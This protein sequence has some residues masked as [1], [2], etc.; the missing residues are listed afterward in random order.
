M[1]ESNNVQN[2]IA[3]ILCLCRNEG[4]YSSVLPVL[5]PNDVCFSLPVP[6]ERVEQADLSFETLLYDLAA[7][8]ISGRSQHAPMKLCSRFGP[9]FRFAPE[10]VQQLKRFHHART[11][12]VQFGCGYTSNGSRFATKTIL[13]R[14]GFQWTIGVLDSAARFSSFFISHINTASVITASCGPELQYQKTFCLFV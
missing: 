13:Y 10:K 2:T 9:R 8:F 6:P 12:R 3:G 4:L 11:V 1:T 7:M 14:L 5:F